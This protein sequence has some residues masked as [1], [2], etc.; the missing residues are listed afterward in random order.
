M[1]ELEKYRTEL[2]GK[3][4]IKVL[5]SDQGE[6]TEHL[7]GLGN[8]FYFSTVLEIENGKK[9][10]FGNDWIDEWDESEKLIE[11]THENWRISENIKFKN[12]KISEIILDDHND[13]YIKLENDI[14]LY[15]TMDYGDGLFFDEYSNM[16][17]S[18]G[19]PL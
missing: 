15:H 5:H 7:N 10:R 4:L 6:G 3:K 2:V 13:I 17:D 14:L 12:I 16:F 1:K 8:A 11:V 19:K 9:Y 18:N